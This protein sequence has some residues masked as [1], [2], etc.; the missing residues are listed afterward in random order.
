MDLERLNLTPAQQALID[1]QFIDTTLGAL[2]QGTS[3]IG[4]AWLTEGCLGRA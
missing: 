4:M 3:Y 1:E 2:K